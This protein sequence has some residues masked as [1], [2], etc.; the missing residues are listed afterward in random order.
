MSSSH[1]NF[2]HNFSLRKYT[3]VVQGVNPGHVNSKMT[4]STNVSTSSSPQ[5]GDQQRINR[6]MD[7]IDN[8]NDN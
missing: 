4:I 1:V 8:N 6:C 3:S 2:V 7:D 5:L